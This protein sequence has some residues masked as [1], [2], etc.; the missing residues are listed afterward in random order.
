M[1]TEVR[2]LALDLALTN[3][4]LAVV[5]IVDGKPTVLHTE[6]LHLPGRRKDENRAKWNIR[7]M[8]SLMDQ[9]A[10]AIALWKP[11]HVAYEYPDRPFRAHWGS[12]SASPGSEFNAA[13]GLGLAEGFLCGVMFDMSSVYPWLDVTAITIAE[14]KKHATGNANAKKTSV[15]Q[16]LELQYGIRLDGRSEDE[17]DAISVAM[18]IVDPAPEGPLL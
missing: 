18:V 14:A 7:R 1:T 15:R 11:R 16:Y 10:K 17:W 2:T 12:K 13:Q 3:C 5:D 6:T 4:G 9:L 8:G